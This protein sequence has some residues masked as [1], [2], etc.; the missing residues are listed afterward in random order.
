ML[1][2][3]GYNIIQLYSAK[4]G[5]NQNIASNLLPLDNSYYI[6]NIMPTSLGEG[7]VRF[8]TKKLEIDDEVDT[9]IRAHSF[10]SS[11][12]K[13]QQVIYFNGYNIFQTTNVA[14]VDANHI[15]VEGDNVFLFEK[16]TYLSLRYNDLSGL[17]V[18]CYYKIKNSE[19][20]S[21][22]SVLLELEENS[23]Q[24]DMDGFYVIQT[25]NE[26]KFLQDNSISIEIPV[27]FNANLF[28]SFQQ[29]IKL[30]IDNLTIDLT[31]ADGGIDTTTPGLLILTFNEHIIP[32]FDDLDIVSV[33]YESKVPTISVIYNSYGYIRIAQLVSENSYEFLFGPNTRIDNLSAACVP[34]FEFFA[35]KLWICNGVNDTMTWDGTKLEVYSE[36]VKEFA[37]SFNRI[38]NRNFSFI[39]NASFDI[40]KY[41]NNNL[42]QLR[43]NGVST[44]TSVSNIINVNNLIT[45]TTSDDLPAF[46]GRD[47]IDVFYNDKPPKFSYMKAAHDRLWA[48]GEGA[49]GL[50]YRSPEQSMRFYY[51][52]TPYSEATPFKFFNENTKTVPSEDISAKH[53]DFDN[54]EAIVMV[55]GYVA[56]V[57]RKYT[58]IWSGIDPVNL[59]APNSFVWSSTVPA[60]TFHGDLVVELPNDVYFVSQNGFLSYSTLNIAKQFAASPTSSMVKTTMEYIN[61]I[62]DNFD[63]RLCCSFKYE[64]GGFCGFK[65]GN[66]KTIVSRYN[67][68]LYWWA[69]FS[70]DFY[71][72]NYFLSS[73]DGSLYLY[74]DNVIFRY[75]DGIIGNCVYG[76]N[77]GKNFI[78]FSEVKYINNLKNRYANKRYEFQVDYSSNVVINK[79]NVVKVMIRGDLRESFTIE[80]IY[81]LPFRGDVLGTIDLVDGRGLDP[82][83]PD[84][85][86]LGLRLDVSSHTGKGRLTFVSSNFSVSIVGKTKNGPF[87]FKRIRLFGIA[88]R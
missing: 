77:D 50:E 38:D 5:M 71:K 64:N 7:L 84:N 54:L 61:S 4:K 79:E 80:D 35:K 47:R 3:S 57:G 70:G 14:I 36:Y 45:I 27:S 44:Q 88:E 52:Y 13:N 55:S 82:N 69:L 85:Q 24:N 73:S 19:I 78:D 59:N 6:E 63:Y 33:S 49:V 2:E 60:G 26:I 67:T 87:S 66:N 25:T 41:Q 34:R 20:F 58:Q 15:A 21:N 42:I 18:F 53:G 68:S 74:L 43:I 48:L 23:F 31:I 11:S 22:T 75:G 30:S 1:H 9:V 46:T 72:S 81:T 86:S 40:S 83:S 76:D 62:N 56:F 8:G 39:S 29:K 28:Y 17:S 12:G 65:I 16:D 32:V 51:S 37:N 10:E